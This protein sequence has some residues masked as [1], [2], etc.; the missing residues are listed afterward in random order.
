MGN[1]GIGYTAASE[2]LFPSVRFTGRETTDPAGTL[3]TEGVCVD[4]TGVQTGASRWGD[5]STT[6]VDPVDQCTFWT[7]QEYV[8]LT[9]T[10][11]WN[12]RVCSFRFASCTGEEPPP[13]PP[14]NV[15]PVADAGADLTVPRRSS[16]TLDG[17]GSVD[18][19]G[20][21]VS[22]SWVSSSRTVN[23]SNPTSPTPSFTTRNVRR[24]T[25]VTV[26]LTVTDDDGAT[27][28]DTVVVTVLR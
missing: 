1:I 17:T 19:D 10:F 14:A 24:D 2:S 27:S 25:P 18:S 8:E 20:T 26:T 15:A 6:A 28:T 7:F 9:G 5:Y 21:I 22:Y 3:Q 23:I 4:G 11:Q 12:T 13:P 16:G